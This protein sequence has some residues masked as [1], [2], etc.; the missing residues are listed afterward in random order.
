M[1][2]RPLIAIDIGTSA[3]KVVELSGM[4]RKKLRALGLET[5]PPGTV[6]NGV[7]QN[8]EAVREILGGLLKKL[9]LSTTGRRAALSLGGSLVRLKRLQVA[10]LKEQS[11]EEQ[12]YY[13]AEQYFQADMAEIYFS[14]DQVQ[15]PPGPGGETS[16][17][18]VGAKREM[19]EQYIA[20]VR[21]CGLRTGV[22][23]CTAFS[24]GNMFEYNYGVLD[25]LAAIVNIGASAS[26]ISLFGRGQ[27]LFTR[28]LPLGGDEYS[29]RIMETLG[30]DRNNAEALKIAVSQGE[31][32]PAAPPEGLTK[33][34]GEL[35]EQVVGEIQTTVEYFFQTGEI[36]AQE[37]ALQAVYLTGGGARILGLDAALAASLQIPVQ[38]VNPFQRVEVDPKRFQMEHILMQG[39]LYGVAVGLGMRN[40]DDHG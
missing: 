24:V 22:V 14:F 7:I 11:L 12:M 28:D 31:N 9:R 17:V 19:V 13:E 4:Q 26:Q 33:V 36:A 8:E 27:Y 32:G 21:G 20:V 2:N 18:L 23:E 40:L 30:V 16:V 25:G 34:L 1:F 35:N 29:R 10:G 15:G 5:L 3:I 38:I 6:A 39:H 37:G